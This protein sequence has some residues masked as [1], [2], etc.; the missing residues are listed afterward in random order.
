MEFQKILI[1]IDNGKSAGAVALAGLQLARQYDAKIAL[2]TIVDPAENWINEQVTSREMDDLIEGNFN[3]SQQHVIDTVFK[4]YPVK[5]FIQQ[6]EPYEI[7]L[8]IADEWGADV[9][10][11]GTHGRKGL[12]HLLMGSVAEEVIRHSKKTIV[13]I[14]VSESQE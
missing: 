10:V 5:T 1:A 7:I 11:L 13:V 6:G 14:P 12:S 8:K 9:I 3:I 2:V 4:S